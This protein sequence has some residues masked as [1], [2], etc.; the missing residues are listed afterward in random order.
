MNF[1][2]KR[3]EDTSI[4]SKIWLWIETSE[5]FHAPTGLPSDQIMIPLSSKA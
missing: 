5:Q 2:P 4:L 1:F 3:C